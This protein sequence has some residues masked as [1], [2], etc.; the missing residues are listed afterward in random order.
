MEKHRQFYKLLMFIYALNIVNNQTTTTQ[1][2]FIKLNITRFCSPITNTKY[3]K[4]EKFI[5]F[6][7]SNSCVFK[8]TLYLKSKT[9]FYYTMRIHAY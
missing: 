7:F 3:R 8:P 9:N 5:L 6:N 2:C 4:H 1:S